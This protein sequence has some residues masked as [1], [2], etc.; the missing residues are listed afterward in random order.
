MRGQKSNEIMPSLTTKFKFKNDTEGWVYS[1]PSRDPL[2][3]GL[4]RYVSPR[5]GPAWSERGYDFTLNGSLVSSVGSSFEV[6]CYESYNFWSLTFCWDELFPELPVG[7]KI[8]SVNVFYT[9]RFFAGDKRIG[10]K[11]WFPGSRKISA[12]EFGDGGASCNGVELY[13]GDNSVKIGDISTNILEAPER[14]IAGSTMWSKAP[15]TGT[16]ENPIPEIPDCWNTD[17][18]TPL[19]VP[20]GYNSTTDTITLRLNDHLPTTL[21]HGTLGLDDW[22]FFSIHY[23]NIWITIEYEEPELWTDRT[24]PTTNFSNRSKLST[25]YSNRSKPTTA[26]TNRIKTYSDYDNRFGYLLQEIGDYV[27]QENGFKI[28]IKGIA[29]TVANFTNRILPATSF[30]NRS[31]PANSYSNRSKPATNWLNDDLC[32]LQEN[33]DYLQSE[34]SFFL[35]ISKLITSWLDRSAPATNYSNRDKPNTTWNV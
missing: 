20:A 28:I 17:T 9:S 33:G 16:S 24:K 6:G 3:K 23:N 5:N 4:Q 7:A 27:L 18:G 32:L 8:N 22:Y 31:K 13:N 30:N 29:D 2:I 26:F 34:D 35:V 19:I 21:P 15:Y 1:A 14:S 12:V 10:N 25:S 11:Y